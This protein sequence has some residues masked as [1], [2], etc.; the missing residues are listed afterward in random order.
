MSY[1]R[2]YQVLKR[3]YQSRNIPIN[4]DKLRMIAYKETYNK[5]GKAKTF[6]SVVVNGYIDGNYFV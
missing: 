6:N 4:E 1:Q 5:S 2:R 3:T